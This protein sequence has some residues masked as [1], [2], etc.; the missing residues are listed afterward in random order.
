[1]K[2]GE[3]ERERTRGRE[4]KS[5]KIKKGLKILG[6]KVRLRLGFLEIKVRGLEFNH[7]LLV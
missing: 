3:R 6:A 1:L 5:L 4:K 2:E 7:N